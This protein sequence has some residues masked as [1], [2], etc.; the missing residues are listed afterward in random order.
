MIIDISEIISTRDKTEQYSVPID[1]ASIDIKGTTYAFKEKEPV[2]LELTNNGNNQILIKGHI[3]VVLL[4]PCDRCLED[5]QVP[6][7]ASIEKVFDL[8][9]TDQEQIQDLDETFY[10]DHSQLDVELLVISE[11]I[12]RFPMKTLCDENCKGLCSKCGHNLNQGDCGC[13]RESLDPRMSAIQ[14]IFNRF[15]EV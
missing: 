2:T 3:S 4:V 13:D 10:I 12:P 15:K 5:V 6:I 8:K 14:D 7:K 1:M 11:I 9:T